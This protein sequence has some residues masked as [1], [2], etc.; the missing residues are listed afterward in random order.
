[1]GKHGKPPAMRAGWK[2]KMSYM[3]WNWFWSLVF[4]AIAYVVFL[5]YHTMLDS[6]DFLDG[7]GNL[8]FAWFPLS[9]VTGIMG[10]A[11]ATAISRYTGWAG[12]TYGVVKL[13]LNT[14]AFAVFGFAGFK[15][16]LLS[17]GLFWAVVAYAIIKLALHGWSDAAGM[18]AGARMGRR[19]GG[20]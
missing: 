15:N 9:I 17:L 12:G 11:V 6:T 16:I 3:W 7:A 10:A 2:R 19:L 1:M 14:L 4:A 18:H 20:V 5:Q 13:L 8:F